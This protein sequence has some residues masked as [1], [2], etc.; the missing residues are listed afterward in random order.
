MIWNILF[1]SVE[2]EYDLSVTK[3]VGHSQNNIQLESPL[4]N[5]ATQQVY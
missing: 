3:F 1:I 5:I 2:L 4:V